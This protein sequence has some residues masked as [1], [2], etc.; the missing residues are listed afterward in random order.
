[1]RNGSH[2]I[3]LKI[4]SVLYGWGVGVRNFL[5]DEKL[6]RG[7]KSS[8]PVICV[9][10]LAV[11]GTGKTPHVEWLIRNLRGRYRIAVLTRG[12]GRETKRPVVASVDDDATV[13]GDEPMQIKRKYPDIL[14]YVDG[15]R[16]RALKNLEMMPE[17]I[18]PEV[19]I[20]DDGFQHRAVIPAFS[21]LLTSYDCPFTRDAFLPYGTL[22]DARSSAARADLFV[23]THTPIDAK[24]IELRMMLG[25]IR[26]KD[27]QEV[28]FSH[29]FYDEVMPLFPTDV[30]LFPLTQESPVSA[31]A[32]IGNPDY[33]FGKVRELYPGM[34]EEITFRDHHD[35][36]ESE[37]AELVTLLEEEP[38][39]YII[40]TEKDAM[41]LLSHASELPAGVKGR[42]WYLPI[43]VSFSPRCTHDLLGKLHRAIRNNGL[44][45]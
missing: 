13:I 11:G 5:Y 10:N 3:L 28:Y 42:I 23:I 2:N 44:S 29:T 34:D 26:P 21:I 27:Y 41:R 37:L 24:P 43:T 36:T 9:G 32:A 18:R 8:I 45:L 7:Y 33:F 15:D 16:R 6:R 12:Y 40:T 35:F 1:M 39:R 17:G 31:L 22:R 19:V 38:E 30:G 25:E 14:L 20:M 4:P